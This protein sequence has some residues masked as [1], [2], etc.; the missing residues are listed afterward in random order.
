MPFVLIA[1]LFM[2]SGIVYNETRRP[3]TPT[4]IKAE[5]P[6]NKVALEQHQPAIESKDQ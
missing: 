2:G 3:E 6:E 1:A 5:T 4:K